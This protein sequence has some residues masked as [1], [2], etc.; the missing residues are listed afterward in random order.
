MSTEAEDLDGVGG[1]A[2]PAEMIGTGGGWH[3]DH[4]L[5]SLRAPYGDDGDSQIT[6]SPKIKHQERGDGSGIFLL[7]GI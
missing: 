6:H 7:I 3:Y 1:G 5:R 4:R 2:P